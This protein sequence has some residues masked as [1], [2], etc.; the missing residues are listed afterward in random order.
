MTEAMRRRSREVVRKPVPDPIEVMR[1]LQQL[2]IAH[3][4][5]EPALREAS[6]LIA[7]Q[8]AFAI[9]IYRTLVGSRL[10]EHIE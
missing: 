5:L 10:V 8:S 1:K 3:P 7:S 2:A 4:E 6:D 9:D